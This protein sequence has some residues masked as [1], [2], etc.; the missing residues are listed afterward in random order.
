MPTIAGVVGIC[1]AILGLL[2]WIGYG[3]FA[4]RGIAAVIDHKPDLAYRMASYADGFHFAQLILGILSLGLGRIAIVRGEASRFARVL[5][6]AAVCLG[7][8]VLALLM[9]LV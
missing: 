4:T 8:V 9:L 3:A 2:A 7:T 1:S 5:G 6:L